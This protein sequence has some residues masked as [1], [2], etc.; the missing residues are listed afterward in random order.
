MSRR[1]K[2]RI[3]QLEQLEG[4]FRPLLLSCLRECAAGRWG[5]FG[6]NEDLGGHLR[7][8]DAKRLRDLAR[9]IVE[10]RAEFGQRND[11]CERLIH[12]CSLLGPHVLG[13]PKLAEKF[14]AELSPS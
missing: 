1:D 4:E 5:L 10:I 3:Q 12:Y 14:L 13:E 2:V 9:D 7:W 11:Q 8:D 6:Q